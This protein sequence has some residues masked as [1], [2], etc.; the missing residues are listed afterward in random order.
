[1][2]I[3]IYNSFKEVKG[4]LFKWQHNLAFLKTPGWEKLED[5]N[6]SNSRES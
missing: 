3:C 5:E 4:N 6:G 2:H 1:M